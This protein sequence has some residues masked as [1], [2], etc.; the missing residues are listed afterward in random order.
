MDPAGRGG[1]YLSG[2]GPRRP[3]GGPETAAELAGLRQQLA[4]VGNN[5]NQLARAAH[6]GADVD[7][8]ALEE[9]RGVLGRIADAAEAIETGGQS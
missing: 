9:A 2:T 4:R 8:A 5:V 1:G 6:R 3:A 7:V